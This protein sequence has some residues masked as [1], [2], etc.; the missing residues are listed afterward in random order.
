MPIYGLASIA[1]FALTFSVPQAVITAELST[2]FPDNGGYSLW[3]KA[4]FGYMQKS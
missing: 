1:C 2:A 3:V 4:A